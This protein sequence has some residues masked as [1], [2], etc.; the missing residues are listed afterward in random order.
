MTTL[1]P[2][3]TPGSRVCHWPTRERGV[4]VAAMPAGFTDW[5]YVFQPNDA[6]TVRR[7]CSIDALASWDNVLLL[8]AFRP[9]QQ[10]EPMQTGPGGGR[11][12]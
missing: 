11:A 8:A 6:P 10:A 2:D 12:A 3:I 5:L 4:I 1:R 9:M 7:Y